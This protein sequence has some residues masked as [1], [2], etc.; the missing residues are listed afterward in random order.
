[1]LKEQ[2]EYSLVYENLVSENA[3]GIVFEGKQ[4]TVGWNVFRNDEE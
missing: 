4:A 1:M 3:T 2:S